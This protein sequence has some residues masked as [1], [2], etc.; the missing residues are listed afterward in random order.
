MKKLTYADVHWGLPATSTHNMRIYDYSG[1]RVASLGRCRAISYRSRKDGG[2]WKTY[3][4]VFERTP[5]L[6]A[7]SATRDRRSFDSARGVPERAISVGWLVDIE[8]ENGER[9]CAPGYVVATDDY[10]SSVWIAA[11][12]H[13]APKLAL[14]QLVRG[15]IVTARGIEK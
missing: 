9:V 8:L 5:R 2:T 1:A 3:R 11:L 4:H 13:G 12:N 6:L 14:E 15:P 10:G 7:A